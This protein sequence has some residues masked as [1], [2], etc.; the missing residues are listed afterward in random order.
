[1][2]FDLLEVRE[3]IEGFRN[4]GDQLIIVNIETE[5]KNYAIKYPE[6]NFG[7]TAT[8]FYKLIQ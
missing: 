7:K 3:S 8:M 6:K 2:V 4:C 1:L 5:K